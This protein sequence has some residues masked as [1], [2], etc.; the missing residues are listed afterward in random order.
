MPRA[1]SK[2]LRVRVIGLVAV[3]A[4]AREATR[5][6]EVSASTA[7]KW[8]PPSPTRH[9]SRDGVLRYRAAEPEPGCRD[10]IRQLVLVH[11][12]DSARLLLCAKVFQAASFAGLAEG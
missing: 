1:Y 9:H 11:R 7:I 6:F 10:G 4:S 8:V 12:T 3:G 2:D 5:Q